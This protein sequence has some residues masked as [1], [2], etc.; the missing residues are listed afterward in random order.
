MV[1][2]ILQIQ[3]KHDF[4]YQMEGK[5]VKSKFW[6]N[7]SESAAQQKQYPKQSKD[8]SSGTHSE[9]KSNGTLEQHKLSPSWNK[10]ASALSTKQSF[11]TAPDTFTHTTNP[12]SGF[13]L[14]SPW[15][16][17][18]KVQ[19]FQVERFVFSLLYIFP[20]FSKSLICKI[21]FVIAIESPGLSCVATCFSFNISGYLTTG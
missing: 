5:W 10:Q 9:N 3:K 6:S 18:I 14:A 2:T 13:S 16:S 1:Q 21:L 8:Q 11:R 4:W 7:H 19:G 15:L 20:N 17:S 12:F